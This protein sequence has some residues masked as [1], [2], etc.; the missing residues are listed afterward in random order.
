M[1]CADCGRPTR[2]TRCS[3]CYMRRQRAADAAARKAGARVLCERFDVGVRDLV[4][5]V[6]FVRNQNNSD[7]VHKSTR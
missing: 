3:A 7:A 4:G 5:L 1:T 6:L 2:R